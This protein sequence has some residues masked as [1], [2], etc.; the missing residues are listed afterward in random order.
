[1]NIAREVEKDE[2]WPRRALPERRVE[3][4]EPAKFR[5]RRGE[6]QIELRLLHHPAGPA[7]PRCEFIMPGSPLHQASLVRR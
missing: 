2:P 7:A 4:A 1:M 3:T 6:D 5:L